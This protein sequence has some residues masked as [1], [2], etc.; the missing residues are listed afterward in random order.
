MKKVRNSNIEILRI[1]SML[2]IVISHWTVHNGVV[3][4]TIELGFNRIL[5]ECTML[6][7]I[8]VIIYVMITGYFLGKSDKPFSL[9]KI[10]KLW[11]QVLFYSVTIYL[12][13]VILGKETFS[14]GTLLKTLIPV[15]TK[16]YWFVTAFFVLMILTPFINKYI[17][18]IKQEEFSKLLKV[19]TLLFI[20]LPSLSIILTI[21]S[22]TFLSVQID[23]Y[24]TELIQFIYFYL[25]GA[26]ISKYEVSF[27]KKHNTMILII[28]CLLLLLSPLFFIYISKFKVELVYYSNYLFNRNS[29]LCVLI[30]LSLLTIFSKKRAFSDKIINYIAGTIFAV[31]LISDNNFV[32]K[33]LWTD[34]FCVSKYVLS[35]YLIVNLI[36]SVLIIFITCIIIE[37]IRKNT[38]ERLTNWLLDKFVKE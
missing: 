1:I 5:L 28:S 31:Y 22:S 29:I 8:G 17:N 13:F 4:Q 18:S 20:L 14:L 10:L 2:M 38:I 21:I 32:R 7:N 36:L 24:G 34:I 16:E 3:N 11:L 33:I 9:K 35:K 23:F 26:Y 19:S 37:L 6:G 30:S 15:S 27:L 12:L 25:L